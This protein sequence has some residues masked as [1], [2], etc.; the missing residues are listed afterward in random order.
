M[1]GVGEWAKGVGWVLVV[2]VGVMGCRG[3]DRKDLLPV[4]RGSVYEVGFMCLAGERWCGVV[5]SQLTRPFSPLGPVEPLFSLMRSEPLATRMRYVVVVEDTSPDTSVDTCYYTVE[6]DRWASPQTVFYLLVPADTSARRAVACVEEIAVGVG[7]LIE[8]RELERLKTQYLKE[9]GKV[10]GQ[11][12]DA[13]RQVGIRCAIPSSYRLV[14]VLEER[15]WWR[16]DEGERVYIIVLGRQEGVVVD[17]LNVEW[18]ATLRDSV[19]SVVRGEGTARVYTERRMPPL[20]WREGQHWWG[21]GL[22]RLDVPVMGGLFVSRMWM[23]GRRLYYA[24]GMLFAP[25]EEKRNLLVQLKAIVATC[26]AIGGQ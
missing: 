7:K 21:Q 2:V 22:W 3:A 24:E 25:G 23:D 19:V 16:M 1:A 15:A 6:Y 26:A 17:S 12:L 18:F 14:R 20:V 10:G 8:H 9:Y 13:M 4:S 5:S 11:W